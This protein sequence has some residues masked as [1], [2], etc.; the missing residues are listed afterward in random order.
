MTQPSLA[1]A[2]TV[3]KV[4]VQLSSVPLTMLWALYNRAAE[5]RRADTVFHD[6]LAVSIANSIDYDYAHDFGKPETGQ[7]MRAMTLD[8][9]LREWIASHPMGQ[10]VALGEGLETQFSRVDNGQIAWLSVDL[11]E[12]IAVR[13]RFLP[14][15]DRRRSLACSAFDLRWMDSVNPSAPLFVTAAGLFKY[16]QPQQVRDL[17]ASIAQRFP[18][19]EIAFDVIPRLLSSLSMRGLFIKSKHYAAPPM[20]F[21]LNRSEIDTIKAWHQ[22]IAEVRDIPYVPVRGFSDHVLLPTLR[23]LPLIGNQLFWLAHIICG[24]EGHTVQR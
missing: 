12:S 9:L 20:P 4:A 6:P 18:H 5:A 22:N 24:V 21:G 3:P 7:V 23:K 10:I 1:T 17:V 19:S 2:T 8:K 11:P 16:F 15:T 14:G 13:T